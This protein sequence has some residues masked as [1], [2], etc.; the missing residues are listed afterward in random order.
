MTKISLGELAIELGT[1]KSKLHYF[2]TLGLITPTDTISKMN[3]FDKEKTLEILKK[4]DKLKVKGKT[5]ED[6]KEEL[7]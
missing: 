6:I 5:L 1:S 4:I 3:L 7:K 2:Y